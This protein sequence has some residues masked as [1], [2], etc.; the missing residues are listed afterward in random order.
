MSFAANV[1]V[2]SWCSWTGGAGWAG[3]DGVAG[4]V[5]AVDVAVATDGGEG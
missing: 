4:T 3:T 2:D 5:A 1:T